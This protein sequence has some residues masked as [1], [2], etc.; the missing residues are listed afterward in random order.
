[1]DLWSETYFDLLLKF[2]ERA[3]ALAESRPS[4]ALY[5]S[6]DV[7]PLK[8]EDFRYAHEQVCASVSSEST[9]MNELLQWNDLYGEGGSRK[10]KSLSY[11]M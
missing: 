9:N 2:Q 6:A 10:K 1:M 5:S 4:P 11:F 8:M 3:S 7:R